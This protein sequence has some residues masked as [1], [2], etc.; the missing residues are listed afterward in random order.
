MKIV[1]YLSSPII[2]VAILLIQNTPSCFAQ[3][4][5]ISITANMPSPET[6]Y[7]HVQLTFSNNSK[8]TV[9][10]KMPSWTP[11]Y[12]HINDYAQ[13]VVD[14][15]AQTMDGTE[16]KCKKITKNTWQVIAQKNKSIKFNYRFYAFKE[17]VDESYLDFK[18]AFISPTSLF[19]YVEGHLNEPVTLVIKPYPLWSKISTGLSRMNGMENTYRASDFDELF[20]CPILIGNQQEILFNVGN[21]PYTVAIEDADDVKE[22]LLTENLSK[23]I[24]SATKLIGDIPYYNYTFIFLGEGRGGLEH[25][26]SMAIFSS[27]PKFND[28]EETQ[29]WLSYVAHEFFHLY[30]VKSIRPIALGP[31]DYDK[32]NYTNMLWVSE[33]FTVYYENIIL[34]RANLMSR[35]ECF[36]ELS[37]VIRNYENIPGHLF[38]SATQSSMD[39]WIDFFN[40]RENKK[41]TSISY[42][43]KGCAL[44]LLLDLKIRHETNNQQSLDDVMRKLYRDFYKEK[45]RGFTDNEFRNICENIATCDLSEIFDSYASTTNNIDYPK[46]LAYA[47]LS[48]DTTTIVTDK[49]I[50]GARYEESEGKIII[51]S[52]EYNSPAY[53]AGLS[54]NDEITS[55]NGHKIDLSAIDKIIS[56]SKPGDNLRIGVFHQ[57]ISNN[58]QVKLRAKTYKS[59]DITR[60]KNTD[61]LQNDI[62]SNWIVD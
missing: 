49:I 11:G 24:S 4:P 54:I 10:V 40:F 15:K 47:G 44:G 13:N 2:F 32:E 17:S 39:A 1:R 29:G 5:N 60:L 55:I 23:I 56:T 7:F 62:Y 46:Y 28:K 48:I 50:L 14:F 3:T 16:L 42:Y 6:H 57:G 52:V 36:N 51:R 19:M 20:D 8:D 12:Y 26:N 9:L 30:N 59:F 33:G 21:I 22:D 34:N 43:D 31:F 45:K 41:N 37:S 38:Q 25:R 61:A 18:K 53:E 27:V 58:Y 35:E